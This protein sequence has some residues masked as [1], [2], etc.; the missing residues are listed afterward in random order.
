MRC[1]SRESEAVMVSQNGSGG[2]IAEEAIRT[3][4]NTP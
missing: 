1:T 4:D 2:F 3:G